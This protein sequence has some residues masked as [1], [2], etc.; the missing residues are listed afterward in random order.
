MSVTVVLDAAA[1]DVLDTPQGAA[2]RAVLRRAIDRSGEVCCAAVT[3]AE[4]CRGMPRTRRVEAALAR[5]HGGKRIQVVPTDERFAKLVGAIL[6]QTGSGSDRIADAHAV[7]VCSRSDSAV[8][9]TSDPDDIRELA[10]A[11]RGTR[12][13]VRSPAEPL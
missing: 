13:V 8:V 3:L 12:I 1:F 6:Y 2:L 9:F 10:E 11:I 7:A 4:V 5:S